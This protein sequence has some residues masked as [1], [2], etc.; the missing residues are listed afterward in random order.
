MTMTSGHRWPMRSYLQQS[1]GLN[2]L[3]K[4]TRRQIFWKCDLN[5]PNMWF[6][7]SIWP[8]GHH[9]S[10]KYECSKQR[11]NEAAGLIVLSPNSAQESNW[12]CF[13]LLSRSQRNM[14]YKEL[15]KTPCKRKWP[16]GAGQGCSD[17]ATLGFNQTWWSA[18]ASWRALG[19]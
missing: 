8:N 1:N 5:L 6:R 2:A 3:F 7:L 18:C 14:N 13:A 19:G 10:Q 9:E 17:R 4:S 12:F 11:T 16:F 15:K